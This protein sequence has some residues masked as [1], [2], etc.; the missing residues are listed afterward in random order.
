VKKNLIG[1]LLLVVLGVAAF[2]GWTRIS[3]DPP[4]YLPS[5]LRVRPSL[6]LTAALNRIQNEGFG[7]EK[8]DWAPVRQHAEEL[9]ASAQTST[10]TYPAIRY[11]LDQLP[12]HLSLLVPPVEGTVGQGYGLQVLFPE[13]IVATV[14]PGGAAANANVHPGDVVETVLGHPPMVNRDPRARGYFIEIPPPSTTLHVRSPEGMSRD[15]G[16]MIGAF[17]LL[18]ADTHRIGDDVGYVMVPGTSRGDE[19]AEAI[20]TGIVKA[21]APKVCGWIVDLR[22]DTGGNLRTMLESVRPI[23]GEAPIGFDV[24]ASGGRTPWAY[25]STDSTVLPLTNP[26]PAVAV[27]TSRLTAGSGESVVIAFRGRPATRVFG[28]PT[29]GAPVSTRSYQLPDGAMLQLTTSMQADRSGFVYNG[30]IPPD[31]PMAIDWA[32]LGTPVDPMI[33]AAGTWLRGQAACKK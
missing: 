28:E 12:D 9:A 18:P 2:A 29:W 7:R 17:D 26:H 5:W 4:E 10:D 1:L 6:F 3:S 23:A 21:D 11:A 30:R 19:I 20:R 32:R 16:L 14:Y 22:R 24:D 25:P 33:L 27:L 31:E 13:R 8:I 15:V